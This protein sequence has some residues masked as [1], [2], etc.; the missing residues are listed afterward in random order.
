MAATKPLLK[1]TWKDRT[2]KTHTTHL[3]ELKSTSPEVLLLGSS[4]IE[5]FLTSGKGELPRFSPY[6]C[7]FAGVGGDGVQHMIYRVDKGLLEACPPQLHTVVLMS[8]TNNIEKSSVEDVTEAV[9]FLIDMIL[10]RRPEL[11]I[12]LI[13]LPPRDSTVK[14]LSNE[15]LLQ[16]VIQLN[17]R[18]ADIPSMR[19]QVK[20]YCF[21][22]TLVYDTGRRRDQFF[23]DHVHLN[24]KGYKIF[25]DAIIAAL[26]ENKKS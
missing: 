26:E 4:M 14:K 9:L 18:L 1:P 24:N 13:G 17:E 12:I 3:E 16:K 21:Y 7:F 22:Q 20:Y 2:D 23:D 10:A 11:R 25:G 15:Q 5:R 6:N 19:A 8:G